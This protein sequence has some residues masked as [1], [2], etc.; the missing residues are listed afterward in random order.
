MKK[1]ISRKQQ[2]FCEEYVIDW[3]G[4]HAAIRAGYS[5]KSARNIA[6]NNLAKPEIEE[7]IAEIQT[8]L[9]KL[10]GV[11]ALRNIKELMKIAY[12]SMHHFKE[13][14]MTERSFK[15]LSEDDKAAISEIFYQDKVSAGG[16]KEKIV[17]FKLHDK[18]KAIEII[19]KMLGFNSPDETK[20]TISIKDPPTIKFK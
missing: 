15:D 11:S 9:A 14:W 13:D 5:K 18:Q 2:R 20:S 7:Y 17:K 19:N 3:N 6:A 10:A 4:T 1:G 8:D 12:S 16:T